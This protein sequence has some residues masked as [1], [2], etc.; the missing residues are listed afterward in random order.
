MRAQEDNPTSRS[1]L[2]LIGLVTAF[3]LEQAQ[4]RKEEEA[5]ERAAMEQANAEAEVRDQ[6]FLAWQAAVA[7]AAKQEA[8]RLEQE[9]ASAA[10][11]A[12]AALDRMW[13]EDDKSLKA[14]VQ[15]KQ[16]EAR[17]LQQ[18]VENEASL[19]GYAEGRDEPVVERAENRA[20]GTP[21]WQA[22]LAWIAGRMREGLDHPPQ[23][24]SVSYEAGREF[25]LRD[26]RTSEF[27]SYQPTAN[28]F[29]ETALW[30]EAHVELE[31]Q[32]KLT[33]NPSGWV[34]FNLSNGRITFR[35]PTRGDG[36]RLDAFVQPLA[37][38]WGWINLS[39]PEDAPLTDAPFAVG[40][41]MSATVFDS[42]VQGQDRFT[43][44]VSQLTGYLVTEPILI[45]D[46][47]LQLT[48]TVSLEGRV[49]VHRWTRSLMFAVV[50]V[51]AII[52][53]GKVLI[54]P[55]AIELVRQGFLNPEFL[56]VGR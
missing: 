1:A 50:V 8:R 16:A 47:E 2:A 3:V 12:T 25:N 45:E 20:D 7:W 23:W 22:G 53:I 54:V 19:R 21:W 11:V 5:A 40:R 48:R 32:A 34:D 37:L 17:R 10:A 44:K 6:E 24:L 39:P 29:I 42:D 46:V 13:G 49:Q 28:G 4:R 38:S 18:A 9:A 43:F 52:V 56:P 51:A 27:R 15:A 30:Q 14:F 55:A 26:W 36:S 33:G 41:G 35:G 31:V